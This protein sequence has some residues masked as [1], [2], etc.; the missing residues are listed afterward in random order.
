MILH[1]L[2]SMK[3]SVHLQTTYLCIIANKVVGNTKTLNKL[4]PL[5]LEEWSKTSS[6]NPKPN[7]FYFIKNIT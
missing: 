6:P 2:T 4:K 3:L 7:A 1:M 5:P